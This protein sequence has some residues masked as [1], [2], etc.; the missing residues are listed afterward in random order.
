MASLA[1]GRPLVRYEQ[2]LVVVAGYFT[3]G[4][5]RSLES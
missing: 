4:L 5:K 1:R 3:M 2:A